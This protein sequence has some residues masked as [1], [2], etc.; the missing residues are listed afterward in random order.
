MTPPEPFDG[1]AAVELWDAPHWTTDESP[2]PRSPSSARSA[3]AVRPRV[4][5]AAQLAPA[6]VA[7]GVVD[8]ALA[9]L[10]GGPRVVVVEPDL[11]RAVT[12]VAWISYALPAELARR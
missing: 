9:A 5:A 1:L 7:A 10:D 8:G 4:R 3:P 11:E 2:A 6:G 12:W